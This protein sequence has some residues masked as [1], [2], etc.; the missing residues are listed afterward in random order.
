MNFY[1]RAIEI[2]TSLDRKI[3]SEEKN[4]AINHPSIFVRAF[5]PEKLFSVILLDPGPVK[6]ACIKEIRGITKLGLKEAKEMSERAPTKV[7]G[8]LDYSKAI[9]FMSKLDSIGA[10]AKIEAE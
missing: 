10:S 7:I 1:A 3:T 6:I 2:I 8:G 4:I 9:D 5:V